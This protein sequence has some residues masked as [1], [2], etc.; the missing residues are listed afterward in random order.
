MT[1][2]STLGPRT[3]REDIPDRGWRRLWCFE[4]GRLQEIGK[5][6]PEGEGAGSAGG[7]AHRNE[8]L[9]EDVPHLCKVIVSP[10]PD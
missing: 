9:I 4:R 8:P 10:L 2:Y 3:P 6:V 7:C 1:D 5:L